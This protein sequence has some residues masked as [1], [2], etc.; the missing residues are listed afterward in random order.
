[1]KKSKLKQIIKEE[2]SKALNEG[3]GIYLPYSDLELI[4]SS[5]ELSKLIDQSN[6]NQLKNRE[7]ISNILK[8]NSSN[9]LKSLL[10]NGKEFG[11]NTNA[12]QN[13][14]DKIK[15]LETG[16]ATFVDY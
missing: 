13:V 2:I 6:I 4:I 12:L 16:E 15:K 1:M 11:W 3:I 5:L 14:V 8:L 10:I 7:N 9:I